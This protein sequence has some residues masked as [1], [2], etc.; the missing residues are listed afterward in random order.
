MSFNKPASP[1]PR[2]PM[3]GAMKK[4][5][6]TR[7]LSSTAMQ[8]TA[9]TMAL[10]S[11][12]LGF[13]IVE[14]W[15]EEEDGMFCTYVHADES[16][17]EKYPDIISGHYPKHKKEHKISP[18]V[19]NFESNFQIQDSNNQIIFVVVSISEAIT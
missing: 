6:S 2:G 14:I 10:T 19:K 18:K 8:A 11:Q 12:V 7:Y 16:L 13:E 17:K 1:A 4:Q 9:A 5:A 3:L 15:S